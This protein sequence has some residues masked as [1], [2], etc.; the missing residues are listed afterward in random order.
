M[1]RLAIVLSHPVQYYS[2]IFELLTIRNNISV[3]VFYTLEPDS[4]SFDKGFGLNVQWDIPLLKGYEYQFVSNNGNLKKGF[5]DVKN[6]DLIATIKNW[7]PDSVLVFGWS[8]YSHLKTL[9][10]FKGKIPVLFRGDSNMLDEKPGYKQFVRRLFLKYVYSKVNTALYVGQKNKEYYLVHGLKEEQL[11]YAPHAIDNERFGI[12]IN[13]PDAKKVRETFN[14]PINA[15]V[16][17]FAGK[18]QFKKNP[19]ILIRAYLQLN[20]PEVHLIMVGNGELDQ[21]LK[22]LALNHPRIHFAGFQNQS[23]LPAFYAAS[24]LFC[25]PS[26]GPGETWGLAINEAMAAGNAILASNKCGGAYDLI[27]DGING[28][29]F[30]ADNISDLQIKLEDLLADKVRLKNFGEKSKE[31]IQQFSFEHIVNEIENVVNH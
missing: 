5:F 26:N 21:D 3:K 25:L 9:A 11:K 13:S 14:I 2:P 12:A 19:G 17:L 7:N 20:K 8:Y 16:I 30:E 23:Q 22:K 15:S 27:I 28:F 1:K 24:D 6:A 31:I 29:K 18:F 4:V 10:F